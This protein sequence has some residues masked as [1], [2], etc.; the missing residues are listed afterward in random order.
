MKPRA[1]SLLAALDRPELFEAISEGLSLIAEHVANL[2]QAAGALHPDHPRG[3]AALQVVAGEEAG[4]YLILLDV[5]RCARRGH[6]HV[7][8]QLLRCSDHVAKG[9][10]AEM[11]MY[12]PADARELQA[13][14]DGMR[15][16]F[17]LDGPDG[18]SGWIFRNEIESS[19]ETQMY[20]DLV[21]SDG[22]LG[23]TSHAWLDDLKL[24]SD[25]PAVDLVAALDRN[26][27]STV[28]GL[29][30]VDEHWYDAEVFAGTPWSAGPEPRRD[31]STRFGDLSPRV[32]ATLDYLAAAGLTAAKAAAD[33]GLILETWT[34]PMHELL[35][36][37]EKLSKQQREAL[38]AEL[39]AIRQ[40]R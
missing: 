38:L 2:T 5:A 31:D 13:L 6:D 11:P 19:R 9:I 26:G 15:E 34:F 33:Q 29:A 24:T 32:I 16:H 12:H 25:A 4:K 39:E 22:R 20:V 10:Y 37:K 7:A 14:A 27:F 40:G 21:E 17:F 30:I 3:E 28:E 18:A 8:A 23:W 35:V 1:F 36:S